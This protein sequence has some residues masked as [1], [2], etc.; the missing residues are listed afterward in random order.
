MSLI[1]SA[2]LPNTLVEAPIWV[3]VPSQRQSTGGRRFFI[4]AEQKRST[5][6]V[7][8]PIP[9]RREL[10]TPHSGYHYDGSVRR[11]F[12]GWYFKVS[13]PEQ[14]ESFCFMYSAEDPAFSQRPGS[15]EELLIGPRFP[16]I[17]AQ[18]LGPEEKYICQYSNE[19]QYF[20]GSRHELALGN[21]FSPKKGASPPK[22]EINPEEFYRRVEEGFQVTPI[23]HQ[24]FIRDDGRSSYVQTVKTARWEY[25]TR[26]VYGWGDVS[27]KQK[28]T[29]GWLAAFPVFEPHWQICM[30]GG[31]ST[32]W[33]EWDD[34]RY[35]F[36]DAP[37]Y[38]EKN[39]GG[40][41][42][43]RWFWVQ[44][45]VFEGAVGEV[46][47]TA[48]GGRRSLPGFPN[49][50]EE[51]AM[52][53]VHYDG[54]LFEFVPWN[55][56]VEWE[57][58]PWGSWQMTAHNGLYEVELVATTKSNGTVLRA[59]TNEAGLVPFCKDTCYG[60]LKLK[61]WEHTKSHQRGKVILDVS[62]DLAAL[63]VGGGPW[64]NTWKKQSSSPSLLRQLLGIPLDVEEIFNPLPIVKPPGL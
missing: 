64:Y 40:S 7:Y 14:K 11:F 57:I 55:G 6:P 60:D 42:P 12:E 15:L 18:I 3:T 58:S 56:V 35:E 59:P 38:S 10:R 34:Q 23:W 54:K 4:S 62:S 49:T 16:G 30:A 46:A 61:I 32:G 9:A 8:V 36:E 39:W 27:F 33:I 21:T 25:S 48:G 19:V 37:S 44:C 45:N 24:G 2:P 41:F 22:R 1:F 5:K 26:P 50:Y 20:W 47:L 17:G 63:E 31:L 52:V 29:A 53:G 51:V 13:L 43:Q 28:A